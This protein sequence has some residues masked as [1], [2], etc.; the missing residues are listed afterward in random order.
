[1]KYLPTLDLWNPA[2]VSAIECD[3]IKL[4][5]GQWVTCGSGKKA[6]YVGTKS[7]HWV[8]HWQGN[9]HDTNERFKQLCAAF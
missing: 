5:R 3:Q 8:A 9:A 4:Q 1:M 6:R 7:T 2:I